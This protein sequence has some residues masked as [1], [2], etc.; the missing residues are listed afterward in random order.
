MHNVIKLR[1]DDETVL[2]KS[3]KN[4]YTKEKGMSVFLMF[5]SKTT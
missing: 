2:K 5:F 4:G 3:K 1:G